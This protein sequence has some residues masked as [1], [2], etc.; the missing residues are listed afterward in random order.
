VSQVEEQLRAEIAWLKERIRDL[1]RAEDWQDIRAVLNCRPQVAKVMALLWG[2]TGVWISSEA[3]YKEVFMK[4]TGEGPE[5]NVV[6]VCI[7]HLR[8]ALKAAGGPAVESRYKTGYRCTPEL[9]AWIDE[10]VFGAT[11]EEAA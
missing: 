8:A 5:T 3:I 4:P 9:A 1:T 11:A 6:S 7:A 10:K 2:R